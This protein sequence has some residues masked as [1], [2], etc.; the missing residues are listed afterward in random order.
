MAGYYNLS[1]QDIIKN[2][3]G[4]QP[5]THQQ[6]S[7][8]ALGNTL[9][10]PISGYRGTLLVLPTAGGKTF[11]SVNWICRNIINKGIKVLWLAQSSYLLDQAVKTFH[12]EIKGASSRNIVNLR[13][14]SS[15]NN[16]ANSG[17]IEQTDDILICT[18]QTAIS[19]Y[20][21][22]NLDARGKKV[23]TP[24]RKFIDSC[25][26]TELFV[27]ID[28]AHHTPAYGCRSL[29][30]SMRESL[31]NLYV[32]G[33]TAT[34]MHMDKRIS[35]WLKNIYDQ[36]ICYEADKN[37]LQQNKVLAVPRYIEKQTGQ[38]F[39]VDD[40]LF[41]RLVNKHK[42]LPDNIIEHLANNQTRNNF[43]IS[44]YI[45]NQNEYGK[46]IIFADRWYQCEYIVDKLTALGIKANAVY[47]VVSG[48]DSTFKQGE[49][50]RNDAYNRQIMQ[51]FRDGKYDV[52]VNV[53]MLTEG[54]D[55]PDV[56]TVMI[57]RQTTSNI[58]LTQMIG[59]ALRGEKAG[60]GIGKDYANIVFFHDTWKRLLPWASTDG[61]MQ[62]ERPITQGRPWGE[63]ISIQL[64]KLAASEIEY[65]GFENASFIE[66]IPVGFLGCEYTTAI[67][68]NDIEELITFGENIIVYEFNSDKY[69]AM[70]T[71]LIAEDL[72]PYAAE[73]V[74][75]EELEIFAT[76]M[77]DKFF[78]EKDNFD[79]LLQEN[80]AKIIRHIAQNGTAP[81][82]IDFHE[83]NLYDIDKIAEELLNASALE[84]DVILTNKFYD[85]GLYWNFLYKHFDT[86]MD[87]YY[88]SQKRVLAR[89]RGKHDTVVIMPVEGSVCELTDEIKNQVIERDNF[90]CLCCGKTRKKGRKIRL[91]VDHILPVA[92]GGSNQISNLQALCNHCNNIKAVNEIDYRSHKTP[93]LKPKGNIN[94]GFGCPES[95]CDENTIMR[96]V[97]E[98]YHCHAMVKLNHH[99]RR[100]GKYYSAWEIILYA[101]ND[102]EW[103]L[104]HR[105]KLLKYISDEFGYE[106]VT[107]LEIKN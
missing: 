27:V 88:K 77:S 63:L 85:N 91:Q 92:M 36:W 22:E 104:P 60:G 44:D 78:E 64:I 32:L 18:T 68:E 73:N 37:L 11:T 58:L 43:I 90:T 89:L 102:P 47:S 59:R 93:L 29:I 41:D 66:F 20:S 7:F 67:S 53:K 48:Q 49:G 97:N 12:D 5:F 69:D 1:I 13:V 2:A 40:S 71:N 65:K 23:H 61:E 75:D 42:D 56:K 70:I 100:S 54:V 94:L 72:V 103:L 39:E 38:E 24:F 50:R 14:V 99:E 55:V 28:E 51:D 35:G 25:K 74:S 57:T 45:E 4:K 79:G 33:L 101:G 31:K 98:F 87:A 9:P 34:P 96:I 3:V 16:H 26:D 52:L 46:T 6:E 82:F 81:V 80:I 19:A 86:F 21:A 105:D 17:S 8:S 10:I 83:R 15:S 106:H 30:I 76:Q 107:S 95:D 84:T 62:S